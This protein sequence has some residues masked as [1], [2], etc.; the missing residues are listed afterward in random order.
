[1]AGVSNRAVLRRDHGED[2]TYLAID[3]HLVSA[4]K[5]HCCSYEYGKHTCDS[6]DE[7]RGLKGSYVVH[8]TYRGDD[9]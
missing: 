5:A 4:E 2:S 1:M 6:D 9:C 3:G 7:M 8:I